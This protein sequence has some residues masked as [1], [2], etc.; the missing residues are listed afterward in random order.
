MLGAICN[1]HL[2]THLFPVMK[3]E[4]NEGTSHINHDHD[5]SWDYIL[6]WRKTVLLMYQF[7][8]SYYE[9]NGIVKWNSLNFDVLVHDSFHGKC[10]SYISWS[11]GYSS[12]KWDYLKLNP[13]MFSIYSLLLCSLSNIYH[14]TLLFFFPP[15]WT[16]FLLLRVW[17]IILW[18]ENEIS[19]I[20]LWD[21]GAP[22]WKR[23]TLKQRGSCFHNVS[24]LNSHIMG[25]LDFW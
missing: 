25:G 2:K 5:F 19:F 13:S 22:Q 17:K 8:N 7:D 24:I 1:M 20:V 10:M 15:M 14:R 16:R 3:I 21:F 4:Q 6:L 18:S 12:L 11:Y 23:G 9:S